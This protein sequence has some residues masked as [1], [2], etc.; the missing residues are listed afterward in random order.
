MALRG[1][2]FAHGPRPPA[3]VSAGRHWSTPN[4]PE[5]AEVINV[6]RPTRYPSIVLLAAFLLAWN[7]PRLA[8]AQQRGSVLELLKAK[9]ELAVGEEVRGA[10]SAADVRSPSDA[11]MEAWTL[12]GQ[13]G[14]SVT[15]DMVSDNL[16]AYLLIVGPGLDTTLSD[17][18]GGGACHARVTFTFL[19][20]GTFHVVATSAMPRES[21]TYIVRVSD[22]PGPVAEYSCGGTNPAEL[23][24]LPTNGRT[25]AVGESG[26]G[27]LTAASPTIMGDMKAEAWTLEGRAGESVAITLEAAT[28]DAYLLVTGPGLGDVLTDDDGAGDL[29]SLLT[30]EF[31]VDGT[32]LVVASALS[33]SGS[34]AYAITVERPPDPN[35][36]PTDGR[37]I[38]P[39]VTLSGTLTRSD[40]VVIDGRRAQ[41]WALEGRAG[42]VYTIELRSAMF[43]CFLYLVGPGLSEPLSDDDSGGDLDSRLTVTLPEDGTY[44]VIAASLNALGTGG[45]E[46]RATREPR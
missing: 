15:V 7:S 32:Y 45:Y 38:E 20:N 25:L 14:E 39:G 1:A 31:P 10:L 23:T 42:E 19:E 16:D 5:P 40:P 26:S 34:G 13:A 28:F 22:T 8:Q 37:T 36:L 43:D 4:E 27:A 24:A 41:A 30:V 44:R 6:S 46:L 29:N 35:T 18:D 12:E 2:T 21:G 11:F 17:D 33:G 3:S 9:G